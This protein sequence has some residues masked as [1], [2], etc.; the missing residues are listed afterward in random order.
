MGP[1]ATSLAEFP[2]VPTTGVVFAN[3]LLDNLPFRV[4]ERAADGWLE[5]RV[6]HDR[7]AFVEVLVPAAP[8]LSAEAELVACGVAP[9]GA[10]LPVPSSARDW[11]HA[12]AEAL[13][14]G[15]LAVVD[16]AATAAELVARGE[17]G[18][19]RTYREHERGSSPL[20][21]PG[22][23]DITI[24]LP[25]E[26]IV[27]A[28][29]R[30]GF[31]LL[32]DVTQAE[33]LRSLGVDGLVDDARVAWQAR[34]HIG[35]LEAL[36]HRSRV[37]EADALLDPTG[38][39][40]HRVLVFGMS[41]ER[42]P[43]RVIQ[44]RRKNASPPEPNPR[45]P[46]RSAAG[47][48]PAVVPESPPPQRPVNP[49]P[50]GKTGI[51]KRETAGPQRRKWKFSLVELRDG[52]TSR[53]AP[54]GLCVPVEGALGGVGPP[55][56]SYLPR[57]CWLGSRG[58]LP[59]VFLVHA[60]DTAVGSDDPIEARQRSARCPRC[61]ELRVDRC[62]T[63]GLSQLQA[64]DLRRC[65]PGYRRPRPWDVRRWRPWI[66]RPH[67]RCR[68]RRGACLGDAI[69]LAVCGRGVMGVR[70]PSAAVSS[71]GTTSPRRVSASVCAMTSAPATSRP[72]REW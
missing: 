31:T 52:A 49:P 20:V 22:E 5:V 28:A 7:G 68:G 42:A 60:L 33:W 6:G 21:A 2:A 35:D 4:V 23:Q 40:A 67:R 26:Y 11:L 18:W 43:P 25:V 45:P 53:S 54:A 41:G 39:G 29:T 14:H 8:E 70:A 37:S 48:R 55:N 56:S 65:E 32:H 58:C 51:Q 34:A 69:E 59:R 3:E 63:D 13:G 38:L 19:L 24:D 15:V 10:R 61:D 46:P 16:Y 72:K 57:G 71:S 64:G 17:D 1:I 36:R 30:A 27:H 66:G 9:V 12:C 50:V 44:R 47:G 62:H